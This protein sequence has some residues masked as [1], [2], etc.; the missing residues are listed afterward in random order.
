MQCVIASWY[1]R[2]FAAQWLY[3]RV[4]VRRFVHQCVRFLIKRHAVGLRG[5]REQAQR[6]RAAGAP[7][8]LR[9][10]GQR[11]ARVDGCVRAHTPV[12]GAHLRA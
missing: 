2:C 11:V 12:A 10:Q 3:K 1:I 4:A 6:A 5:L 8:G 7:L 9:C